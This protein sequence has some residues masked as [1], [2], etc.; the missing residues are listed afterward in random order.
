MAIPAYVPLGEGLAQAYATGYGIRQNRERH[1]L[2]QEQ[3]ALQRERQNALIQA[4]NSEAEELKARQ[5]ME[6]LYPLVKRRDPRAIEMA[7]QRVAS[8]NPQAAEAYKANPD[9][10]AEKMEL[11]LGIKPDEVQGVKIGQY[12]PGDYTPET[13]ARFLQTKDPSV[14]RRQYAPPQPP[15]MTV[16]QLPQGQAAF[17]P[18][19]GQ[20]MPLSDREDQRTADALDA[21]ATTA[22]ETEAKAQAEREAA[23]QKKLGDIQNTGTLLSVAD[24]LIDVATGSGVGAAA[25]KVNAFFG[26]ST[27]GAD[28]IAS[29]KIIQ[30]QLM[31]SMPRMEGPQSDRDVKLYREAAAELGDPNV[32]RPQ[33]KAAL[34]TIRELQA[35]YRHLNSGGAASPA[36][37]APAPSGRTYKTKSGATVEIID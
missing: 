11:A 16:V 20:V 4:Q 27:E 7:L 19:T 1:A 13:W 37:S 22:A 14:L 31:L 9:A 36:T 12:N 17:N 34:R 3:V 32:P 33:K 5:E 8:V 26:R 24:P 29:L 23:I 35:T 28:A 2:D 25:N 10:L 21:A 6:Q 30:A 18:R 15:N